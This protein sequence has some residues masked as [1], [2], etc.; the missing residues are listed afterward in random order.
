MVMSNEGTIQEHKSK[1]FGDL[2]ALLKMS[3]VAN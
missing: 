1:I 2:H 3:L